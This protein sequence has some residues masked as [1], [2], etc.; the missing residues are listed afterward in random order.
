MTLM[1]GEVT[2]ENLFHNYLT[3]ETLNFFKAKHLKYFNSKVYKFIQLILE[4][5]GKLADA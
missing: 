1:A 4:V 2:I 3:L 5:K